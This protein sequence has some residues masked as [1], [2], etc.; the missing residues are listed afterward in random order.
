[1]NP[2]MDKTGETGMQARHQRGLETVEMAIL[3]P[4]F[5]LLLFAMMDFSRLVFTQVSLQHAIREGG[6][7]GVTGERLENPND[8]GTLQSRI[9]S[10]KRIVRESAVG[11]NVE[12]DDIVISSVQGGTGS[13]G[14]PGDTLTISLSH[15]FVFVT[16]MIGQ[17]LDDNTYTITVSTSFRNEP[18]PPSAGP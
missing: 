13:A 11:V 18:F 12:D 16:P 3:L 14:G 6:R 15:D 5:L 7:F 9:E 4:V 17:Y 10:I 1:M 2:E 8:P